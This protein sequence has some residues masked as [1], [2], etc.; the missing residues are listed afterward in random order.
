MSDIKTKDIEQLYS[1]LKQISQI[2]E[3][4]VEHFFKDAVKTTLVL[5]N[6]SIPVGRAIVMSDDDLKI[7]IK[8]IEASETES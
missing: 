6:D 7:V 8:E 5:R 4:M 3:K 2:L 1:A